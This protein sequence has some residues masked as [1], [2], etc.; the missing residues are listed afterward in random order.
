MLSLQ[1]E[2]CPELPPVYGN[3]DFDELQA[4]MTRVDELVVQSGLEQKFVASFPLKKRNTQKQRERLVLALRCVLVR[5]LFQLPYRRMARELAS[6]FVYQKFCG[7]FRLDRIDVPSAKTLERYEKLVSPETL[8]ELVAHVNRIAAAPVDSS[9]EHGMSLEAPVNL[10]IEY[11]DAT[12]FKARVH[13]PVDWL[14]LRDAVRTLTLAI[15]QVRSRNIVSRMPKSPQEYL[16]AM[17][18]L[19]IQMTHARR[20]P[21]A[22]KMRKKTLRLMKKLLRKVEKLSRAHLAKLLTEGPKR[23]LSVATLMMLE[24]K[25]TAILEQVDGI[26]HQA[27]ERIIGERRIA[28]KDK[29]L[30][31]YE[32]DMHVIVRGKANA[33]VEFG[34]KLFLAEQA[35]GLIIDW[36]LYKDQ[37]PGDSRMIPAHLERMTH[38]G[39]DLQSATGDR[40]F[41]SAANTTLL[42]DS[43]DNNFCPRN[44]EQLEQRLHEQSFRN[45]QTRRAQTEARIAIL[46]HGF[47]GSPARKWGYDNKARLCA[48]GI[49]AH[50]LWVLARLPRRV[51]EKQAQAA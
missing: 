9:S 15:T 21:D 5:L 46:T 37:A 24:G 10:G 18:K 14:L 25:F 40:G 6:N 7:I 28:N 45:H 35:D 12:A 31:L 29:T 51:L 17:N 43:I 34:N 49:L 42:D 16:S 11:V 44:I 4:L 22:K 23:G 13:H 41:D 1:T 8:R 38:S 26:I 47:F 19:C 33:E 39:I 27:H 36:E 20:T 50:N 48:W 2:L 30:S 3:K 32:P